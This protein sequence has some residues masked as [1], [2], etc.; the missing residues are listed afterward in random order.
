MRCKW[1]GKEIGDKDYCDFDCRKAFF[2]HFDDED[3][4][5]DR[6]KPMLIA[7]VLVSIPFIVLFCGAGVTIMFSL[8]GLVMYS[9]PF[10]SAEL[11]KKT[12]V[13][14]AVYRMKTNGILVIL[15]GLPFLFLTY[16][17]FF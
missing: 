12:T 9:H 13:K 1:C 10:P 11:R 17:P 14:D 6:K 7:C 5:K 8:L 4:Y 2:D 16:T 15:V 3:K